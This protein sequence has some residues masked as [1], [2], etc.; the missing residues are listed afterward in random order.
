MEPYAQGKARRKRVNWGTVAAH[1]FLIAYV[2]LILIPFLWLFVSSL[3]DMG[4]Y[5]ST[6]MKTTWLPWPLHFENYPKALQMVPLHLYLFN[7]IW[8]ATVQTLLSV[9][10]SALVAYGLSRFDFKGQ[11]LILAILIASMLLPTQVTQI[12]LFIFY[13]K[14]GFVNSFKPLLIP[15]IFGGAWNIF[16]I[17]QF[18]VTL[19]REL[20]EAALADGAT[21]LDVFFRVILP[22]SKPALVVTG[23]FTF[24]WSWKDAWGPLIYL[25]S[26]NLYT[27]PIGLLYFQSP[28]QAEV[29]VQLAAIVI[30]LIPTV[31]FYFLGQGYLERGVAIAELK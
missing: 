30:A 11:G 3:K 24:L 18:M 12:P 25:N 22:Q 21:T 10:S 26:E 15:H 9:F 14:I 8:L 5:Y 29:T 13:S 27:L 28:T 4:Q 23:L 2:A 17:R 7:S 16:L 19:P 6:D 1:A 20:D 31:I